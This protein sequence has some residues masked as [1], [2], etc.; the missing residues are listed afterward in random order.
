MA[1]GDAGLSEEYGIDICGHHIDFNID[2]RG[3]ARNFTRSKTGLNAAA[4]PMGWSA[5]H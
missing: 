1:N 5:N 2:G 3:C 4:S